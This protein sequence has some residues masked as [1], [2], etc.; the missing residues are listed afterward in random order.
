MKRRPLTWGLTNKVLRMALKKPSL[1]LRCAD[2]YLCHYC[3]V[4]KLCIIIFFKILIQK[5]VQ[6]QARACK[7]ICVFLVLAF[8][9][10]S[11]NDPETEKAIHLISLINK[12]WQ[13]GFLIVS[14]VTWPD[15]GEVF[16]AYF[17]RFRKFPGATWLVN[18]I[19][20][21]RAHSQK[22]VCMGQNCTKTDAS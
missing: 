5:C 22:H 3:V 15:W 4:C 2:R 16:F 8:L 11:N 10:L 18:V 12:C 1:Y 13:D 9:T 14:L 21:G 6:G 17:H 20:A 7:N 19:H